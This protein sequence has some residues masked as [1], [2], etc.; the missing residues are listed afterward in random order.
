MQTPYQI[1][2]IP[3]DASDE[4]IKNAYLQKVKLNPPD[5]NQAIFQSIQQAYTH[6]K[7]HHSRVSYQLF[8]PDSISFNDI[9]DEI[10]ATQ[11][12]STLSVSAL[13]HVLTASAIDPHLL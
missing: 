13:K 7:D 6:I 2:G 3:E 5:K 4:K 10:L 12:N 1:L 11:P 9:V 8:N